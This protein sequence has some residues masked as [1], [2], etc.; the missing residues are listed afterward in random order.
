[1]SARARRGA[2][3][4]YANTITRTETD[5]NTGEEIEQ[6]IPFMKGYTVFNVEQIEGLAGAILRSSQSRARSR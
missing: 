6:D 3:V 1:M 5:E 4:V 2:L